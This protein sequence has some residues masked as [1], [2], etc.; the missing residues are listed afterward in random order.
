MIK[1]VII[2]FALM[3]LVACGDAPRTSPELE[4]SFSI[5]SQHSDPATSSATITITVAKGS[6]QPQVKA[7][8][9]AVIASR[10]AK[11]QHITVKSFLEGASLDGTP[12][13]VSTLRGNSVDHVFDATQGEPVRIPT[14]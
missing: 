11:Y 14:H 7:A 12:F 4:Q 13:A 10:K 2:T 8:A 5:V 3:A 6:K 1:A 9:E